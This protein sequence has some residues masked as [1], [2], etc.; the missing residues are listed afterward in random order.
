MYDI[1]TNSEVQFILKHSIL[2]RLHNEYEL[3]N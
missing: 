1:I 3:I 2:S